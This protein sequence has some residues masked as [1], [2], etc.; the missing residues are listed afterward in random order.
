MGFGKTLIILLVL[1]FFVACVKE[2]TS[3]PPPT[4]TVLPSSIERTV[5][6]DL[7]E[8]ESYLVHYD[9]DF[10]EMKYYLPYGN[11]LRAANTA[12]INL[13]FAGGSWDLYDTYRFTSTSGSVQ[14]LWKVYFPRIK[15]GGGVPAYYS[16]YE[17]H[18]YRQPF[19]AIYHV[20]F[21]LRED[22]REDGRVIVCDFKIPSEIK[23]RGSDLYNLVEI[24]SDGEIYS[25]E[26]SKIIFSK[27]GGVFRDKLPLIFGG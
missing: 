1:I 18:S 13:M 14:T 10:Y 16:T 4:T 12:R 2:P 3:T 27:C 26:T 20:V 11:D 9:R 25:A 19:Y 22:G 15:V 7:V 17:Y 5:S 8:F 23:M 21:K 24:Y 6:L